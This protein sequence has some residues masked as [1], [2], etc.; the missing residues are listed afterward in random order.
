MWILLEF[1]FTGS[2]DKIIDS[3]TPKKTPN[4]KNNETVCF[5]T[6]D[7]NVKILVAARYYNKKEFGIRIAVC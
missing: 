2:N 5:L 6:S 4:V 3:S 7:K 1:Y